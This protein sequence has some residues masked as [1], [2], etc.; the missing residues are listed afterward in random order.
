MGLPLDFG[1]AA[2][3][4][5]EACFEDLVDLPIAFEVCRTLTLLVTLG[6]WL[7]CWLEFFFVA[8]AEF[9]HFCVLRP[10][11]FSIDSARLLWDNLIAG[12]FTYFFGEAFLP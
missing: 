5:A 9:T 3:A 12:C 11:L 4:V 6:F 2:L 7:C 8:A 1:V 10:L